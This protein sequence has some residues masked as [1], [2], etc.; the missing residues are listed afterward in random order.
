[1]KKRLLSIGGWSAALVLLGIVGLQGGL[2][3]AGTAQAVGDLTIDWG[4][5][6]WK[7]DI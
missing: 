6:D 4:G 1:M 2:L 7:S 3:E 5:V